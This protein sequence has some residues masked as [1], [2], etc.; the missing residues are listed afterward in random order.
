MSFIQSFGATQTVT[1]SCHF[2]QLKNGPNI[3]VDCG[4]FQG[5][6]EQHT[7][8]TFDFKTK[9]SILYYSLSLT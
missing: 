8:K 1:G 3:L 5:K 2:L 4:Y 7:S 6:N 9:E